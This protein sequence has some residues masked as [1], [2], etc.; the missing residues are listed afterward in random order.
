MT[1]WYHLLQCQ[2]KINDCNHSYI[3]PVSLETV[4]SYYTNERVS[5]RVQAP[6]CLFVCFFRVSESKMG[7]RAASYQ[8]LSLRNQVKHEGDSLSR[9]LSAGISLSVK[10]MRRLL[11]S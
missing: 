1:A 10:G 8:G 11:L 7:D 2:K 4:V 5:L 6:L 3:P 9:T